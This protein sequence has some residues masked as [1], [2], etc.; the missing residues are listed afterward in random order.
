MEKTLAIIKPDATERNII[1]KILAMIESDGFKVVRISAMKM[2]KD[3]AEKFYDIHASKPF[4]NS[5]IEYMTSGLI[6]AIELEKNNAVSDF[7]DL[8]GNTD[9][10]NAEAGTIRKE[11][12]IDKSFNSV[13]G[14]DSIDNANKEINLIFG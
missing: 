12:A 6:V 9:P 2:S 14:S 8:I 4:F 11:F 7:R 13:H 1:G 10:R 3:K 5:L